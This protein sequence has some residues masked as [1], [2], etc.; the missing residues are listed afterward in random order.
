MKFFSR[1]SVDLKKQV[2]FVWCVWRR[3]RS[4]SCASMGISASVLPC[5]FCIC[6][7]W[8]TTSQEFYRQLYDFQVTQLFVKKKQVVYIVW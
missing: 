8:T 3:W 5:M 7:R 2:N 4:I 6:W 1:K